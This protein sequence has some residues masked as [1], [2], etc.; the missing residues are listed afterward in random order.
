LYFFLKCANYE[1]ETFGA[2]SDEIRLMA[3]YLNPDFINVS[4][5]TLVSTS[6]EIVRITKDLCLNS[7]ENEVKKHA[8][9]KLTEV[10]S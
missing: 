6:V 4:Q 9:L 7:T 3:F 10:V 2:T 1:F 8:F 5:K